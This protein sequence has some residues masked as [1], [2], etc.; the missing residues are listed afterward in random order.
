MTTLDLTAKRARL[1]QTF[2]VSPGPLRNAFSAGAPAAQRAIAGLMRRAPA[3]W[4]GQSAV[5]QTIA[6]RLGWRTSPAAMA[7]ALPRMDAFASAVRRDGF[8]DIVL[9]GMG[10]SSLAPEVLRAV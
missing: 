3:T 1:L 7:D 4:S 9:L 2:H 6:N 5:Q 8:T 10:G